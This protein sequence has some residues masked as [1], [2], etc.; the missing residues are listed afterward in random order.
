MATSA[1]TESRHQPSTKRPPARARRLAR[2]LGLGGLAAA[3]APTAAL[4]ITDLPGPDPQDYAHYQ[5]SYNLRGA[6]GNATV[7]DLR[8]LIS[9]HWMTYYKMNRVEITELHQGQPRST[10]GIDMSSVGYWYYGADQ[11]TAVT[12]SDDSHVTRF[13]YEELIRHLLGRQDADADSAHFQRL[14]GIEHPERA[15]ESFDY[16]ELVEDP[17]FVYSLVAG[18]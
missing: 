16:V 9:Y 18:Q 12:G 3:I 2:I 4:S 13:D 8:Y 5:G 14:V 17:D 1:R 6:F 11:V 15:I 10:Y 7:G